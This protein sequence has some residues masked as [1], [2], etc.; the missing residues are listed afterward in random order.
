MNKHI[1]VVVFK[2]EGNTKYEKHY[3][4]NCDIPVNKEDLVVVSTINGPALARVI[5]VKAESRAV[6]SHAWVLSIVDT[7]S[8]K[9]R[10]EREKRI[11]QLMT[12]LLNV[13]T[14]VD[15]E[16]RLMIA[17]SASDK[18]TAWYNEL[19]ALRAEQ[20]EE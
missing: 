11:T 12:S 14:S 7:T 3:D 18:A 17:A 8:H 5:S 20:N 2:L 4:F 9:R 6:K 15:T 1:A 10:M 19:V 13:Y 16:Q